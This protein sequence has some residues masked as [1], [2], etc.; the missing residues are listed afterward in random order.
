MGKDQARQ[1][2]NKPL[3]EVTGG[4]SLGDVGKQVLIHPITLLISW[5]ST[6]GK[7]MGI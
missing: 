2:V 5:T 4:S 3:Q 7:Q 6:S 1:A